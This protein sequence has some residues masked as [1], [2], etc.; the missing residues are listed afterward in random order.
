ML[1]TLRSQLNA[2]Q[3]RVQDI[4]SRLCESA[5]CPFGPGNVSFSYQFNISDAYQGIAFNTK[6]VILNSADTSNVLGCVQVEVAPI[7]ESYAWY[8]LVFCVFG[9]ALFVGATYILTAYLNPWTGTKN[10]YLW[11]S[12]FGRDTSVIRLI[13]PGFFD[14]VKYLQFAL[15]LTSLSLDYPIYLQP[16]ISTFSWSCL[17]FTSSLIAKNTGD[18]YDG[19]YIGN[20]TYGLELMSQINQIASPSDVWAG[21]IIY[22]LLATAGICLIWEIVAVATWFW[23]K[24]RDGIF[25]LRTRNLSFIIGIVLKISHNLLAYPLLTFSFFQCIITPKGGPIYLTVLAVLVI[26]AWV[27]VALW[28]SRVLIGAKPRQA[29]FD[30]F[31]TM[32][33][34]GTFYST[35]TE[36]GSMF[37]IV[38]FVTTFF[39]G[40]SVGAIQTSGLAQIILLAIIELFHFFCILIIKPFE[41]ETSMNLVSCLFSILRFVLIFLSLPFLNSLHIDVVVRQWLGYMILIVHAIVLLLFLMHGIQVVVEVILRYN[42][43]V[44]DEDTGAIYS[45]KQLAR[46]RKTGIDT[47]IPDSKRHSTLT[48]KPGSSLDGRLLLL[49]DDPNSVNGRSPVL[50]NNG[51]SSTGTSTVANRDFAYDDLYIASPTSRNSF[52]D[53]SRNSIGYYRKPRRRGS[54]YDRG[55]VNPFAGSNGEDENDGDALNNENGTELDA[56]RVGLVSPPPAGVNY[57]VRESDVYFTK[58]GQRGPHKK[59]KKHHHKHR[60]SGDISNIEVEEE[61]NPYDYGSYTPSTFMDSTQPNNRLSDYGDH[62]GISNENTDSGGVLTTSKHRSRNPNSLVGLL[63]GERESHPGFEGLTSPEQGQPSRASAVLD[64]FKGKR[65]SFFSKG[66]EEPSIEPR[67]F[68]VVSR[69]PIQTRRLSSEYSDSSSETDSDTSSVGDN[70]ASSP[71]LPQIPE[72]SHSKMVVTNASTSNDMRNSIATG[73]PPE[74]QIDIMEEPPKA[75]TTKTIV[76]HR[77][78]SESYVETSAGTFIFPISPTSPQRPLSKSNNSSPSSATNKPS[79]APQ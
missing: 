70:Q 17:L 28:V 21:F 59:K 35:Y 71:K 32:L 24:Y 26:V 3:Y 69:G 75:N 45:I 33:R 77:N 39:R 73:Y 63:D 25:E 12:N 46:R 44:T 16:V 50:D 34:Y 8:V 23:Q 61:Q 76:H 2:L 9:I 55:V 7:L 31:P 27:L 42:G 22:F 60:E 51:E 30:D 43:I 6:F 40:V 36:Q 72:S 49:P 5:S 52:I 4:Y 20:A 58:R 41:K 65:A 56:I 19:L 67:G 37:F 57:A 78:P 13:T 54:L 79:T 48:H 47:G 10:V 14:F 1:G 15:F 38:E 74:A 18:L 64:W 68:E 29:I 62:E 66:Y 11:S 53:E